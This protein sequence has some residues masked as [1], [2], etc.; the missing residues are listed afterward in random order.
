MTFRYVPHRIAPQPPSGGEIHDS[1]IV[2]S[3]SPHST[4]TTNGS[5]LNTA[6]ATA[7]RPTTLERQRVL[8]SGGG[9]GG[10]GGWRASE[11]GFFVH[12]RPWV[13]IGC[14]GASLSSWHA[15]R[16][17]PKVVVPIHR[18][19]V[20]DKNQRVNRD[21]CYWEKGPEQLGSCSK[22]FFPQHISNRVIRD[23]YR[24]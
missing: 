7:V 18:G 2:Q 5:K 17:T 23:H 10:D 12:P 19:V 20:T 1:G 15:E 8:Q 11:R 22:E 16:I 4:R 14:G 21:P 24:T 3:G 9:G 13:G 6:T